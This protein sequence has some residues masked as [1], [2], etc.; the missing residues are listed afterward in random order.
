MERGIFD[1]THLHFYTR[2]TAI[3]MLAAAGLDVVLCRA[4]P[5]PLEQIWPAGR[6]T[7]PLT[8]LMALQRLGLLQP[9][10][11]ER[12]RE[13]LAGN[14]PPAGLRPISLGLGEPQH[15]TP[16][17]IKD[18]LTANLGGLARYPLTLGLPEL[19]TAMGEWLVHRHGGEVS[20]RPDHHL[21]RGLPGLTGEAT[22]RS[23]YG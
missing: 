19:R 9:Y 2:R 13:L 22:R 23:S 14:T 1:R 4:T 20:W 12:L 3:D 6:S 15:P 7:A 21:G 16:P 18:A 10:P 5:V 11:F 8:M 17:L